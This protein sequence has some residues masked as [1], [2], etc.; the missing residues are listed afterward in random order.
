MNA[1]QA[2]A[3]ARES[4]AEL[5]PDITPGVLQDIPAGTQVNVTPEDYGAVSVTGSLLHLSHTTIAIR[6]K[7][8]LAG[9]VV[10]HFP[11]L[12]YRLETLS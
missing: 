2:L 5:T 10:V 11:R 6:R 4:R 3:V 9:D 1:E 8:P 12:G 7:D